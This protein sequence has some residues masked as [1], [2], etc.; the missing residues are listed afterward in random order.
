MAFD[1]VHEHTVGQNVYFPFPNARCARSYPKYAMHEKPDGAAAAVV[2]A[3]TFA[4]TLCA[5]FD[6]LRMHSRLTQFWVCIAVVAVLRTPQRCF[7]DVA[8]KFAIHTRRHAMRNNILARIGT[9]GAYHM[10]VCMYIRSAD[11]LSGM[12]LPSKLDLVYQGFR[13]RLT[14]NFH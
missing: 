5:T 6:R 10:F 11:T 1:P 12:E 3:V 9:T 14:W 7:Q 8:L 2:A 13:C 4:V